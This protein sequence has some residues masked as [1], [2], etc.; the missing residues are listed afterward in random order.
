[1]FL[2]E[3]FDY[4]KFYT[5][6]YFANYDDAEA[7]SA[8]SGHTQSSHDYQ[9]GLVHHE[10]AYMEA[11]RLVRRYV[12]LRNAR[13]LDVGC[14][15]GAGLAVIK[16]FGAVPFGID[17]SEDAVRYCKEV[18]FADT[19]VSE[20][21]NAPVHDI[22]VAIMNDV[23]EHMQDPRANLASLHAVLST[24]GVVYVRN[25]LFSRDGFVNNAQ[26]FARHFEPPYHCSY[27]TRERMLTLFAEC[28][29][30]LLYE[31]PSF[32][33]LLYRHYGRLKR[34]LRPKLRALHDADKGARLPVADARALSHGSWLGRT[35]HAL[36]PAGYVFI[37][38]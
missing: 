36:F 38:N 12:S 23:L 2:G 31:R 6:S 27:F 10:Q 29:F 34:L 1:M 16:K 4:G 26:Y 35:M 24:G 9:D 19:Y 21:V 37:K 13:V 25:N 5:Q 33:L 8:L 30:T 17:V 3:V 32:V 7:L 18:G 11:L 14:A 20:L 15:Q 22:N 28:G